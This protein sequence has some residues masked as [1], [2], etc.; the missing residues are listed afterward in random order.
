MPRAR[1]NPFEAQ[2]YAGAVAFAAFLFEG[3]HGRHK[4]E[5]AT[6]AEAVAAAAALRNAHPA[7]GRPVMI[8]A[9]DG[10]GNSAMIGTIP[11]GDTTMTAHEEIAQAA[12]MFAKPNTDNVPAPAKPAKARKEKPALMTREERAA[13]RTT[14]RPVKPTA[15]K[16]TEGAEKAARPAK[17]TAPAPKAKK[18]ASDAPA[19]PG[20]AFSMDPPAY[21]TG[22]KQVKGVQHQDHKGWHVE[23]GKDERGNWWAKLT[24]PKGHHFDGSGATFRRAIKDAAAKT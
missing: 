11:A 10:F 22:W 13:A 20:N 16:A 7:N 12:A 6:E 24:S 14:K 18:A 3:R 8:Y 21:A 19:A 17:A 9:I 23:I 15:K 1:L 4:A 5:A 2:V